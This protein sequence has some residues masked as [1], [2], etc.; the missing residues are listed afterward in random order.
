MFFVMSVGA[1]SGVA[2]PLA[3]PLVRASSLGESTGGRVDG[4]RRAEPVHAGRAG[5]F[6]I[7]AKIS[8]ICVLAERLLLEELEDQGVEDVAVLDEDL[9]RVVVRGLDELLDLFVD[10]RRDLFRVVALVA[11]LPAHEGLGVVAAELDRAQTLRHAVLRDHRAGRCGG[12]LDVVRSA[13]RRV[14]EDQLLGRAPAQHVRQLVEHLVARRG[15]LVLLREHH[16]VTEGASAGEDRDLVD[17]VRL[18]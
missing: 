4:V 16:R 1:I 14:V 3:V 9:P 15:V 2:E 11:H 10:E 18:G 7:G 13:G 8:A 17:R 5:R 6:T 12:L